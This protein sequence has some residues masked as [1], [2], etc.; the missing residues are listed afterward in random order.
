MIE[1]DLTLSH[2]LDIRQ[3][4]TART[5]SDQT[6][7]PYSFCLLWHPI[8]LENL[9]GNFASRGCSILFFLRYHTFDTL[10]GNISSR[11]CSILFSFFFSTL[12][13]FRHPPR[14][15]C[16]AGLLDSVFFFTLPHFRHPPFPRDESIISRDVATP[17]RV[18]DIPCFSFSRVGL[19]HDNRY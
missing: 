13:H 1:G 14:Y 10:L 6:K 18:H 3:H 7:L 12:P 2:S 19:D 9:G 17:P 5:R 15:P 4:C 11:G 16:I 8:V